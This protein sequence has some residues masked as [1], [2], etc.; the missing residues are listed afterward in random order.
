MIN[1]LG[2]W[3]WT[4][5]YQ[6]IYWSIRVFVKLLH[7]SN[8]WS[9]M[10][11]MCCIVREFIEGQSVSSKMEFTLTCFKKVTKSDFINYLKIKK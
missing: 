4:P 8:R 1:R 10:I 6:C 2:I 5:N 11:E 3:T 7:G 9:Y